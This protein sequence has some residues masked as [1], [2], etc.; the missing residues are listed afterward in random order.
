MKG[1]FKI[2]GASTADYVGITSS[3][4]CLIHCIA[5][6]FI[7]VATASAH[8]EMSD[9]PWWWRGFD[10]FFLLISFTAVYHASRHAHSTFVKVGL[11]T[12]FVLLCIVIAIHSFHVVHLD[13]AWVYLPAALLIGFHVLNRVQCGIAGH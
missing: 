3:G 5:T 12:S 1:L 2:R 13:H 8:A 10:L 4:L 7:F 6:P 11:Y 9:S